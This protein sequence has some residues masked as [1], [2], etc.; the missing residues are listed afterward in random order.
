MKPIIF[1]AITVLLC[2]SQT[3]AA[4]TYEPAGDPTIKAFVRCLHFLES[5]RLQKGFQIKVQLVHEKGQKKSIEAILAR[6]ASDPRKLTLFTWD[7]QSYNATLPK[8]DR[9][10]W[11]PK[12]NT[13]WS[14]PRLNGHFLG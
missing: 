9:D 3:M 5:G 12:T 11:H 13:Y 8:V 14:C 2:L 6:D 7:G 1:A 4:D 10:L